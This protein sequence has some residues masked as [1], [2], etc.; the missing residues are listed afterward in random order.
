MIDVDSLLASLRTEGV[1]LWV[2]DGGL[3]YRSSRPLASLQL[4]ALRRHKEP[5][6]AHLLRPSGDSG[7]VGPRP[8]RIPLGCAQEALWFIDRLGLSGV[9]Y[10]LPVILRIRGELEAFAL[11]RSLLEIV[12][13]HEILR[14]RYL[15]VDGGAFQSIDV[16]GGLDFSTVDLTAAPGPDLGQRTARFVREQASHRF[17]LAEA[18]PFLVRLARLAPTEHLLVLN[19]HHIVA[20]APSIDLLF[21]ELSTL[22][23]AFRAGR[24]SPLP[25]LQAQ[26]ADYVLWQRHGLTSG[27]LDDDLEYWLET[28]QGAPAS[29]DLP[30]DRPRPAAPTFRGGLVGLEL[31][32]EL[33]RRVKAFASGRGMTPFMVLMAAFQALLSRWTGQSD[34][35]V[36]TPIASRPHPQTEPLIGFFT[37]TVVIRTGLE[38]DPTGDKLLE[39]VRAR[40]VEAYEHRDLPLDHLVAALR[41]TRTLASQALFQ[42]FF[43][44]G[45]VRADSI[46]LEGLTSERVLP[47][48]LTA[49]FDLSL[50]IAEGPC[51]LEGSFEFATDLFDKTTIEGLASSFV[52]FLDALVTDPGT[53]VWSLPL[54]GPEERR[55]ILVEWNDTALPLRSESTLHGLF[56]T[57]AA[58]HPDAL[59]VVAGAERISYAE[60]E[61]DANRIAHELRAHGVGVGTIVGVCHERRGRMIAALLGILKAGAAWLPVDPDHPPARVARMLTDAG[62]DVVVSEASLRRVLPPDCARVI[63]LDDRREAISSQ[64]V[65]RP[66]VRVRPGNL[67]YVLFTSGSTGRPKGVALQHDNAVALM[68]WARRAFG[69]EVTARVLASTSICFDLS[70]FE[71][72]VALVSGGHVVL[73]RDP[74]ALLDEPV[75]PPPTLINMV[76]SAAHALLDAG[77]I[78]AELLAINLAGEALPRSLV[79]RLHVAA[80]GATIRNLYGP[81]EYTTYATSCE[82]DSEPEAPVAI[83]GPIANTRVYLLDTHGEPVPVGATGEV[84][85][86]GSGLSRGYL[87]RPG[88]TADRFRPNPFGS[89]GSRMYATG[90]LARHRSD[91]TLDFVGRRDDQVKIRGFRVE[92]GEIEVALRS[93]L[94]VANAA[95]VPSTDRLGGV[96]LVGHILPV[97]PTSPPLEEGLRARLMEVLPEP[98]VPASFQVHDQLPL[99]P[100]GKIDR[101]ALGSLCEEQESAVRH[102]APRNATESLIAEIWE[103]TLG[104]P[105][106][107]AD[108]D[109]FVLGGHSL[110]AT[111]IVAR[112][113]QSLAS[114]LQLRDIFLAPTVATLARV[115]TLRG[116]SPYT[117]IPVSAPG[118][119]V[120]AS[121]AQQRMWFIEQL[122]PTRGLYN[123]AVAWR[124]TGPLDI[125]LLR[126]CLHELVGRHEVL[127]TA[128]EPTPDGLMQVVADE[129]EP[130]LVLESSSGTV[131]SEAWAQHWLEL[132][133]AQPFDL[134]QPPLLRAG[135]LR[136]DEGVHA[137]QITMHHTVTDGWSLG[138]LAR[139]LSALYAAPRAAAAASPLPPLPIQHRDFSSWQRAQMSGAVRQRQL[140]FW[141]MRLEGA[142]SQLNL[143]WDRSRPALNSGRGEVVSIEVDRGT[144]D[145]IRQLARE[146]GATVFM[147]MSAVLDVLLYR[148]SEQRDFCIGYSVTAHR[149]RVETVDLMG[150]LSNMLVLRARLAPGQAFV[151][152]VADVRASMLEA[153][154]H[155]TLPFELLVEELAPRRDLS[156]HPVFQVTY[157]YRRASGGEGEEL[158][159]P[160]ILVEPI[161]AA[162]R[163][164]KFDLAFF[165]DDPGPGQPLGV[166]V[167]FSADLLDRSTVERWLEQ[168]QMLTESVVEKP[169]APVD[170]LRLLSDHE[171]RLVVE[172]WNDTDMDR[173][174]PHSIPRRFEAQVRRTPDAVALDS[175]AEQ[176]TY[177]VLD[178]QANDLAHRLRALGVDRGELVAVCADRR[179]SLIV[180]LLAILKAGAAFVPLDPRYPRQRL[181]YMLDDSKAAVVL[182]DHHGVELLPPSA[183]TVV[184]LDEF[185]QSGH[186]APPPVT[187][188]PEDL[189]YCLYTSGATGSPKAVALEHGNC[190]AMVDWALA[191]WTPAQTARTLAAT[192]ICFDLSIFEI[193]VPLLCGG[194]VLLAPDLSAAPA[195][196]PTLL[197][198]VPSAAQ[199]LLD[200]CALPSSISVINLAGEAL[201]PRL[202]ESLAAALPG[203]S[204]NNLYGPTECTTYATHARAVPKEDITI[205][206]PVANTRI[207]IL[208][209]R[210]EPV[211]IGVVGDLY[212]GGALVARGYLHRAVLTAQRFVPD[213]FGPAGS[214]MHR[215]GDKARYLPNGEIDF[216]GRVD[217]Q[218]KLKGHRIELGEVDHVLLEHP[219]VVEATTV[220]ADIGDGTRQLVAFVASAGH[221]SVRQELQSWVREALPGYMVPA[222]IVL[223]DALPRT[224]NGKIDC[225]ALKLPTDVEAAPRPAFA[226][227][228]T[229][230]ERLFAEIWADVL[231]TTPIGVRENFFALGGH[232]LHAMRVA[233]RFADMRGIALPLRS[234]FEH[235]TVESLARYVGQE[236]DAAPTLIPRIRRAPRRRLQRGRRSGGS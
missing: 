231:A 58:D 87:N 131:E 104:V 29:L 225:L 127:R 49:K 60:L 82:V 126:R 31:S 201:R 35:C 227:P 108:D 5:I 24:T 1:E 8:R 50:F 132:D 12:R 135:V 218:I 208:D 207:Y 21:R 229:P 52:T 184:S 211:P 178:A 204:I 13:R 38:D 140:A 78:P 114:E 233:A 188:L 67:A 89:P 97:D 209:E 34:I 194:T 219:G 20:D 102:V 182:V 151:D 53:A 32:T 215:T 195:L 134:R 61:A 90:D 27:D 69:G 6:I 56:E 23:R 65:T 79:E 122:V 72:F 167:E 175:G 25:R 170:T 4:E 37:N 190:T 28:L 129:A 93:C 70:L 187:L 123:V 210:L 205:G 180:A 149:D 217:R 2:Q 100:N 113:R 7:L 179:A 145:G 14:T 116:S 154:E 174:P 99:N 17:D 138:V 142:A 130:P 76:P 36:G 125:D 196:L 150:P 216:R 136:L 226:P 213:P 146:A 176:L 30:T 75:S 163:T 200:A 232:S 48:L 159:L 98:M 141:R 168:L 26:Y 59:A 16:A 91:G 191:T 177:A 224:P 42:V 77:A 143:P 189:A 64:P 185:A 199:A 47:E 94:G 152:H 19:M 133:A 43:A 62:V 172:T 112:I 106:I 83:G 95:V 137:V 221:E 220:V 39:R 85:L 235:S 41:P 222:S 117:P 206:R 193:F 153:D 148:H 101:L 73:V 157:G 68:T 71:L 230:L 86:A 128:L 165:I 40:V 10:N 88:V 202:V 236:L 120:L 9:A 186:N 155:A 109:F 103:D 110:L 223:L 158:D 124:M 15:A 160:G 51:G 111:R 54:F 164:A 119:P 84:H 33:G 166:E 57:V 183:A 144:S 228:T 44:Y 156:H 63:C 92:P 171:R 46:D 212:I 105:H 234:I 118:G 203:V 147:V 192:S 107:G 198:T 22:Y 96:R 214:R 181:A 161:E 139:E 80:P 55:K 45:E 11:E 121:F 162:S 3:R 197:N 173:S 169:E 18:A 81:T 66:G 74:L 115:V